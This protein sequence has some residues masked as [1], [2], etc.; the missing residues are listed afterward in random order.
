TAAAAAPAN[1]LP[2]LPAIT[3]TPTT[4]TTATLPTR[5]TGTMIGGGGAAHTRVTINIASSEDLLGVNGRVTQR[6]EMVDSIGRESTRYYTGV[7]LRNVLERKGVN[8]GAAP[9][10]S[11]VLITALDGTTLTLTRA[12]FTDRTTLLAWVEDRGGGDVR[13]LARPRLVFPQ[14]LS[15]TFIQ[16]VV[17][18][19][20]NP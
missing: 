16:Q 3:T 5:P 17:S 1:P 20:F 18:V 8:V 12:E 9:L 10:N 19:Q 6:S 4:R 11:T 15:G 2:T 14:G 13:Q 7:P